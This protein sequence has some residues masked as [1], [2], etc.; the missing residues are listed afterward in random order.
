MLKKRNETAWAVRFRACVHGRQVDGGRSHPARSMSSAAE[1]DETTA[2]ARASGIRHPAAWKKRTEGKGLGVG[3]R[4][5][6]SSSRQGIGTVGNLASREE[7]RWE[8]GTVPPVA[9]RG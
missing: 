1:K 6:S 3:A 2:R 8:E 4:L 7:A 5:G 9:I